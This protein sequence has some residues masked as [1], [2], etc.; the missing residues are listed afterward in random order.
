[1]YTLSAAARLQ[2]LRPLLPCPHPTSFTLHV[3]RM[4]VH[5]VVSFCSCT[6][7]LGPTIVLVLLV[8]L[9]PLVP[10]LSSFVTAAVCCPPY[11]FFSFLFSLSSF[12]FPLLL[13]FH[14]HFPFFVLLKVGWSMCDSAFSIRPSLCANARVLLKCM[15]ACAF[16]RANACCARGCN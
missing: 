9:V 12:L 14:L 13:S 15:C 8:L 2:P 16:G 1:M 3:A 5:E 11:S 4:C 6:P 10:T 7:V